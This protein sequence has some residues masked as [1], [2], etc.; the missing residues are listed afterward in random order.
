M[1][2]D[3]E[4]RY[5]LELEGYSDLCEVNG[6]G[7]CGVLRFIFTTAIVYGIDPVGYVGR[8]CYQTKS[9]A[10]KALSEWNGESDPPGD[11]IKHKGKIE[12]SNPNHLTLTS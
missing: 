2:D 3:K 1:I 7:I 11:W 9:E 12:Y 6:R 4:L 8:Y 10:T 5:S